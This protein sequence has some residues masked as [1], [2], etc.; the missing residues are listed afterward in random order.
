M[1]TLI[2]FAEFCAGFVPFLIVVA[3]A[4]TAFWA[5]TK[6]IPSLGEWMSSTEGMVETDAERYERTRTAST[7]YDQYV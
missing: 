1:Q 4:L 7:T 3:V 6:L 2:A 5:A